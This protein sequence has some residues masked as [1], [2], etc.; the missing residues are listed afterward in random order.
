M[1][2][3][4]QWQRFYGTGGEFRI[5]TADRGEVVTRYVQTR[6]RAAQ[7]GN[8]DSVLTAL[9]RPWREV[10][11]VHEIS[12][13]ELLQRDLDDNRVA[14]QLIPYL[15]GTETSRYPVFPP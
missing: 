15:M 6:I 4:I 13:D 1:T 11:T 9:M 14:N 8:W 5:R 2:F 7:D 10:F 3:G 12:F